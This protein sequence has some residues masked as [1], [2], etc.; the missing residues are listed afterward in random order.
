MSSLPTPSSGREPVQ[1]AAGGAV[2]N[3]G[4]KWPDEAAGATRSLR[5]H[6]FFRT[7]VLVGL[8]GLGLAVA[9]GIAFFRDWH[10]TRLT[11]LA[12]QQA[13]LQGFLRAP[14]FK[15]FCQVMDSQLVTLNN[16]IAAQPRSTAALLPAVHAREE[17]RRELAWTLQ[18]LPLPVSAHEEPARVA[19]ALREIQQSLVQHGLVIDARTRSSARTLFL[20]TLSPFVGK[21]LKR[22]SYASFPAIML[23]ASMQDA[24]LAAYSAHFG[25]GAS[26]AETERF[27]ALYAAIGPSLWRAVEAGRSAR[28]TDVFTAAAH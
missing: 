1:P 11:E 8:C 15:E 18:V 6:P 10:A 25:D 24:A 5:E 3:L 7:L 21:F 22:E 14:E 2:D 4:D 9:V 28:P 16:F 17:T 12:R 19:R 23:D 13:N 20:R 27:F 26:I